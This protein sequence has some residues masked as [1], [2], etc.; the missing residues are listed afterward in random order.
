MTLG[1]YEVGKIKTLS[2]E[3]R[4]SKLHQL[5]A[6]LLT[7]PCSS[8]DAKRGFSDVKILQL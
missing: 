1:S 3:P 5:I 7:I 2:G 4:F 8:A 6:G